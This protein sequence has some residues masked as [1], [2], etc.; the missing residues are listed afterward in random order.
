MREAVIQLMM[1]TLSTLGFS[2]LFYVHPRRLPLASL[3]GFLT[4]AVCKYAKDCPARSAY[5]LPP[6]ATAQ[7]ANFEIPHFHKLG[8]SVPPLVRLIKFRPTAVSCFKTALSMFSLVPAPIQAKHRP[9]SNA[10][11]HTFPR[12]SLHTNLRQTNRCA[13]YVSFCKLQL[14]IFVYFA[15]FCANATEI[16]ENEWVDPGF[17][18][19]FAL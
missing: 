6:Q 11:L 7:P 18:L 4:C 5:N 13:F 10:Y 17:F 14:K 16:P 8:E 2:I 3:G 19:A 1:A 12:Q 15:F 9:C